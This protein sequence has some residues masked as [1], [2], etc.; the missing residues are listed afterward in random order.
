MD[1]VA[2][3]DRTVQAM[4]RLVDSMDDAQLGVQTPCTEWKVKDLLNH[5]TAGATMFALS[6]EHGEVPE[7]E[8]PKLMGGDNLGSD[9]RAAWHEASQKALSVYRQPGVM[10][11]TVTL[12]FGSMPAGVAL[13]IAILDVTTHVCD[14]ATSLGT[15]VDDEELVTTALGMAKQM[16]GPD[17]RRPGFFDEEQPCPDGASTSQ[18]LLAYMGR[19][20]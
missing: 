2:M 18:Q 20:V 17:S 5:V 4:D 7:S 12:P 1:K 6:A 9:F 19:H 15:N 16:I 8:I 14:L 10:D 3:L 11:K 13:D